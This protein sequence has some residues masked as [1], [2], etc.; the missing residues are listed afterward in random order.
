MGSLVLLVAL[1]ANPYLEQ[2]RRLYEAAQFKDAL[3]KLAVARDVPT[4]DV[5][6]KAEILDL[7]A[8]CE[9]AEGQRESAER[10]YEELLGLKPHHVLPKDL[11]PKIGEVFDDAKR[12]L[13]EPDFV[14]FRPLPA[15]PG[16]ARAE[17]VDPWGQVAQVLWSR[18]PTPTAK[19]IQTPVAVQEHQIALPLAAQNEAWLA[20]YCEARRQDGVTLARWGSPLDPQIFSELGA[21]V[22]G[23]KGPSAPPPPRAR[24][25]IGI[26]LGAV[27]VA[28]AVVG[29]VLEL[30]SRSD[31]TG[32]QAQP[33]ADQ[34]LTQRGR[35]FG[36]ARGAIAGFAGAGA[37]A[38]AG[39]VL[40]VW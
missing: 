21:G 6:E 3:A 8:R 25:A 16:A 30:Q 12:H 38:G 1:A 28:A 31:A 40:L 36:E 20:W 37:A 13:F 7:L 15:A 19:W 23:S 33:W 29:T 9:V 26:A 11:S 27:A 14:A 5:R 10:H 34:A 22:A 39:L 32:S 18:R 2:G 4:N 17:L 35:A 24:R